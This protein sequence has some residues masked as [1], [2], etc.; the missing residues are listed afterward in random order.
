MAHGMAHGMA[1]LGAVRLHP[2]RVRRQ[3]GRPLRVRAQ[4]HRRVAGDTVPL[5][6]MRMRPVAVTVAVLIMLMRGGVVEVVSVMVVVAAC[7]DAHRHR[8]PLDAVSAQGAPY[9]AGEVGTRGGL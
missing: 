2:R 8:L 9:A 3:L 7:I 6:R 1:R 5:L 4:V